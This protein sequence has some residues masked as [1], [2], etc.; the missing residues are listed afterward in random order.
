MI[1]RHLIGIPCQARNDAS[2]ESANPET[3]SEATELPNIFFLIA[4]NRGSDKSV[5]HAEGGFARRPEGARPDF[6]YLTSK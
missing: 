3:P 1:F 2:G 5:R 6:F 4:A